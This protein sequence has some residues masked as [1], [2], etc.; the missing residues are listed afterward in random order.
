MLGWENK[1]NLEDALLHAW[2]WEKKLAE[3]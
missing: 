2:Q 1:Y 3:S